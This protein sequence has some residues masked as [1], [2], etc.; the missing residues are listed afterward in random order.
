MQL[1]IGNATRQVFD[2]VYR[3]PEYTG[4]RSQKIPI[5]AQ[6]AISGELQRD[7]VDY[8]IKQHLVYGLISVDAIKDTKAFCGICYSVDKPISV[9]GLTILMD[10]NQ[11]ALVER[12]KQI[13]QESAVAASGIMETSLEEA[14]RPETLTD[15][16]VSAVEENHDD[17]SPEPALAEGFQVR[18]EPGQEVQ[19]STR[20]G[21]RR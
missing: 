7:D 2:F 4:I 13:R 8:I 15:F 9:Q 1:F 14:G 20:R 10:H 12:G 18:R 5:G 21:R 17:S 3:V 6:V 19:S 16:Q 11:R